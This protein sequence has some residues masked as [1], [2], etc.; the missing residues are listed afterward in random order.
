M[1]LRL[2]NSV[3][4]ASFI[5]QLEVEFSPTDAQKHDVL[6]H[7]D[8]HSTQP[9]VANSRISTVFSAPLKTLD[10]K[11]P[12]PS[13]QDTVTLQNSR[14]GVYLHWSLPRG[15]RTASSA[16]SGAQNLKSTDNS[17]ANPVFPL[18][19]NRWLVARVM[20]SYS[21]LNVPI[22]VIDAWVIESDRLRKIEDLGENVDLET[23]VTP[24]VAF[25]GNSS[26]T[27]VLHSQAEKY[28]GYKAPLKGW[29]EDPTA[30]RVPLTIFNS[31]NPLFADY[32]IHNPNVFSMTDN[33]QYDTGKYLDQ[34]T[35]DYIV[36]GWHSDAGDCP[37]GARGIDGDLEDRLQKFLCTISD[38]ASSDTKNSTD[39]T[40]LLSH[41]VIYGV[42]YDSKIKPA[43]PADDYANNF[44]AAVNMEPVSIGTTPLDAVLTFLEAHKL[45]V[46]EEEHLFGAGSSSVA[47]DIL[48]ISELLYAASDDYDSRVKAS[49]LILSQNYISTDGGFT[50]NYDKRKDSNGPPA[51]PSTQKNA[52]TGKSEVDYLN[53]LVELQYQLDITN[54]TLAIQRWSLFAQ[55]F[56]FCSDAHNNVPSNLPPYVSKVQALFNTDATKPGSIQTLLQTQASLQ[57]QIQQI[58]GPNPPL[59]AAR[60]VPKDPFF[61]RS[62][63]SIV[64]AGIDSGW[65]AQFL[66]R[67]LVR[68][69]SEINATTNAAVT[70]LLSSITIPSAAGNIMPTIAK[71]LN[72]G[73]DG[74]RRTIVG[75]KTWNGQPFCPVFI[76]WEAIYYNIDFPNWDLQLSSSPIST[77]NQKQVRYINPSPLS[78][79][80]APKQDTRAC[81]G[82]ILVLPQP[83]FAL[84]AIVKQVFSTA[85][86][87]LPDDLKSVDAQNA[88]LTNIGNLKFISGDLTGFTDSLLTLGTGSHVKPNV[89]EQGQDVQPLQ[90]A[91][92]VT[93]TIGMVKDH[94]VQI[95]SE[96]AKTPFGSL[97]DFTSSKFQPFKGVQQGQ[98]GR[99]EVS[100]PSHLAHMGYSNYQTYNR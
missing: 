33:F 97:T 88:L 63:P 65:P 62:D 82:R 43:T 11:N 1:T 61:M 25:D 23:D 48:S 40:A 85:G 38:S 83:T 56:N 6:P 34:A 28:I 35:C 5:Q 78:G 37:L 64:V 42:N 73:S 72:E 13:A 93:S 10:L 79:M 99:I 46:S 86:Q 87:D 47:N 14:L 94:F 18:V 9:A 95:G 52:G 39:K 22:P 26:D 77:I 55:F 70:T 30:E 74:T 21:P 31:S 89:R 15:Y 98:L 100:T 66:D 80:D 45:D 8:L 57:Q 81:S 53:L 32:T 58:I 75:F 24:Y 49:D 67:I 92:D 17:S 76:E 12:N 4:Q 91:I 69:D 36:V 90:E 59:V 71:L 60:K 51:A 68:L 19:P 16:A 20:K 3:I 44:T 27:N 41:G 7:V 29:T 50:W 84:A 2:D 54:R 96:S